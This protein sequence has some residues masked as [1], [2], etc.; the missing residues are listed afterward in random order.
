MGEE[1]ALKNDKDLENMGINKNIM[2]ILK[3][4]G[5][6]FRW[7]PD[8]FCTFIVSS[9]AYLL[10]AGREPKAGLRLLLQLNKRIYALTSKLA[11]EYGGG[12]HPKHRLTR[13]HDFFVNRLAPGETVIDIGCGNGALTQ[14]MAIRGGAKVT[15][16]ELSESSFLE[17]KQKYGH[18]RLRYLH[19]DVLKDLPDENF[20]V[21]VMSNVL[22]HLEN[23]VDFLREAQ[24]K[25]KPNR[26]LL[27][28]PLYERDWRVPLMDE[29]GVDY[30]LDKTHYIEYTQEGLAKEIEQAGLKI[31]YQEIR[32]GEIWCESMEKQ[33]RKD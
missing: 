22:E 18:H 12:L 13:Y 20:E 26:W 1:V 2:R 3:T 27:R 28:L 30:R 19:G 25:L 14:D 24:L 8:R 17:A 10:V 33:G 23:R 32:W 31:I 5:C 6:M 15:G 16:I 9:L 21:A 29:L 11:C 4:G 7:L